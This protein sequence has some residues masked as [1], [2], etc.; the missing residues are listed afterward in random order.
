MRQLAPAPCVALAPCIALATCIALTA[1]PATAQDDDDG[2]GYLTNLIEENL[3]SANAVV[4]ITGFEGA[5]SSAASLQSLTIADSAGV[6]LTLEDVVLVWS[7]AALLR[8]RVEVDELSAARIVVARAPISEAAAPAPEAQPFALPELP[9]SIELG[10]LNIARIELAEVFVGEPLTISL[11]GNASLIDGQGTAT[12][13]AQ[14]LD[15]K[16]GQFTIS[17]SY[18]NTSA[19]LGLDLALVEGENGIAARQLDLPGRPSVAM[20]VQGT[21]PLTDYAAAIAIATDGQD[22]ITGDVRLTQTDGQQGFAIDIGGDVTPLFAP[23]YQDFFGPDVV[24]AAQ[25]QQ[26]A[27]GRLDLR[28]FDLRAQSIQMQGAA[29][30]GAEGWPERLSLRGSIANPDGAVV[31]LPLTGPKTYVDR[32]ALNLGYDSNLSDDWTAE[33]TIAGYDRPGLFIDDLTV[34]GGGILRPGEGAAIGEV[35]ADLQYAASGLQLDDAGAAAALGDR[36]AGELQANRTEDGPANLT[37]LTLTGPGIE[38]LGEAEIA[39]PSGNFRTQSTLLLTVGALERFSTLADR[40]LGGAAE[41]SILSTIAP[42]DGMFDVVVTGTTN[43]LAVDIAQV[44]P[45]LRGAGTIAIAA[46]RD[47]DGTRLDALTVQ[48]DAAKITAEADLTSGASSAVFDAALTEVNLILPDLRGPA[49]LSG[50]I[51]RDTALVTTFDIAANGPSAQITATGSATPTQDGQIVSA[52]VSADIAE[53]ATYAALAGRD[54]AGGINAKLSGVMLTR[55]YRFD[56]DIVTTTRDLVVGVDQLDPL[57]AGTGT[58]SANLSYPIAGQYRVRDLAI[59]TDALRLRA[60]ANYFETG[61]SDANFDVALTDAG[62]VIADLDG[63][64]GVRGT[65]TYEATNGAASVDVTGDGPGTVFALN[66]VMEAVTGAISGSLNAQVADLDVYRSLIGQPVDGAVNL[67]VSGNALPDLSR[68]DGSVNLNAAD[69]AI[70]NPTVDPLLAGAGQLR[71]RAAMTAA[72][73]QVQE[74]NADFPNVS[75]I[76]ALDSSD[77]SGRGQFDA[78]LRDIGLIAQGISGPATATGTASMA[79]DGTWD[80]D[81]TAT[82]PGAD[83]SVT[84]RIAAVTQQITGDARLSVNDLRPYRAIAGLPLSGGLTARVAG[85]LLPDL[86][87]FDARLDVETQSIAIGTP[88]VDQLLRGLGSLRAQVSQD[89]EGL[90]LRDF[91][92]QTPNVTLSGSLDATAG[93]GRGQFDA[94]LRDVGLFTDQL[95]G[96][97]TATGTASRNASGTWTLDANG[98]GP[99]GIAA[100]ATGQVSAAGQLDLTVNGQVPLGL[101][102]AAIEPR[103]IDGLARLDLTVNGPPALSSVRGTVSVDGA[104]LTAPALGLALTD[105]RGGVT[106]NGAEARVDLRGAVDSGGAV[107]VTGPIGLAAGNPAN[108]AIVLDNV[109]LRDPALYETSVAGQITVNGPLTGGARISGLLDLGPA[110]IQVPSSG[111]GSLGDLPQ[112]LHIGADGAVRQTIARA[113]A[114]DGENAPSAASSGPAYPLDLTIRAPSRVF[115]RGRGLDAEL[116]GTLSLSGTTANIIPVG[117]FALVRGRIDILQQRFE[118]T[119]GEATLQGDFV[120][121]IRLVAQT[122]SRTGTVIRIVVEGPASEPEVRFESVPDLPQDEVLAQLIFGR[123]LSEISPL[124][125]VQ[126]AAAVGTLAGRGGGGLID[127]FRQDIGLDDLDVTTDADGNA[128]VRAG[129]YLSENVYTD[130]TISSD[131]STEVN[132]NLDITDEIIAKGT[133][134]DSGETS[135]GIFFERDY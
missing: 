50:T 65:A 12:I 35:T 19:V 30:I 47:T 70:G 89:A 94:R 91:A 73:L 78:R 48:T 69:L 1:V 8:G 74:L 96:P 59:D 106:L 27:D 125:A 129:A 38:L 7:R 115:I 67:S 36:I 71:A 66:A 56:G 132:I 120:P 109:G 40:A 53:L 114:Q 101:A 105:M 93:A 37:R 72:G 110:E 16:T 33:F 60:D 102:N 43:D 127:T 75:L 11:T 108:L 2:E 104:R 119:E 42:L 62:Q 84:A 21:G 103:R 107:T 98:S 34:A 3:S 135:I 17:G 24:L 124:Q 13:D 64:L 44:D 14:R 29:L 116:G 130:V 25:G 54:I 111:V 82:A 28:Q 5:L 100:Q 51:A 31:L 118:L 32:V 46:V 26:L 117:R 45:L 99:G 76:G 77:G 123:N 20:T 113:G 52:Q 128:A 86:S 81:M 23:E 79:A 6:W 10:A 121:Y 39:G 131:G 92:A 112:V 85:G 57:L 133:L 122:E 97:G 4:N 87:R 68:F 55:G 63:P 83:A 58:L 15:G 9:V 88:T 134:G 126:L 49:R 90:H 61:T 18:D 22:R 95:S 80:L 41:L